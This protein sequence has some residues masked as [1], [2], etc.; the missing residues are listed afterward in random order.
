M[1]YSTN[2]VADAAAYWEPRYAAIDRQAA[3]EAREV[4][5]AWRLIMRGDPDAV[6]SRVDSRDTTIGEVVGES[7]EWLDGMQTTELHRLLIDAACGK[8]VEVAARDLLDKALRQWARMTIDGG[9]E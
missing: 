3:A 1:T 4:D 5:Y 9:D 2:P 8:S 6:H 7:L